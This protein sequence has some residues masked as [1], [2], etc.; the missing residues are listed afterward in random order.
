[1]VGALLIAA[2]V[3]V[4]VQYS[5]LG[6]GTPA[7]PPPDAPP[8]G[9]PVFYAREP[10]NPHG[11]IA[12]DWSGTRRGRVTLPTWVEI[13]RL[14]PAP[15]GSGFFINPATSGDYAAY[16][17]RAGRTLFES[18]DP[19]FISQAWADD[20]THICVLNDY[21]LGTR[22]PGHPDHTAPTPVTS[23]YAVAGCSLRAD[24]AVLA[25][26]TDLEV[27]KLS[28]GKA[29]RSLST[30]GTV[31]ASTDASYVAVSSGGAAPVAVY[32][33]SDLSRPTAVLDT[34]LQPL[35]FSGDDSLLLAVQ[36]GGVVTATALRSGKVAWTYNASPANVGFVEARPSGGDFVLYLSTGPVLLRRDGR[37][38][39]FG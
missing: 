8:S 28:T 39:T 13:N 33:T 17:D 20:S 21:G 14:Q 7:G 12:Y 4:A 5:R 31:V 37:T 29:L 36:P 27:V 32:K 16:F 26:S 30:G 11:L 19:A 6:Q 15:D 38:G 10:G 22:V 34:A 18:N 23:G 9:V 25:S 35:A 1:V 2:A 24:T 3:I